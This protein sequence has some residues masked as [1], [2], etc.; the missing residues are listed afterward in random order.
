MAQP[1][2]EVFDVDGN[3]V[4]SSC[5]MAKLVQTFPEV[6]ARPEDSLPNLS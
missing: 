1:A 5:M 2:F 3:A 6:L 4:C